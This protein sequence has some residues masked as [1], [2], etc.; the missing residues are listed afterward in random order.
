MNFTVLVNLGCV[1]FI[2]L[3]W[4]TTISVFFTIWFEIF[5]ELTLPFQCSSVVD[6]SGRCMLEASWF[7]SIVVPDELLSSILILKGSRVGRYR[8]APIA[9]SL[10][11]DCP[12][13]VHILKHLWNVI[14]FVSTL[15]KQID[16]KTERK[17]KKAKKI[18]F[19]DSR[20]SQYFDHILPTAHWIFSKQ[21]LL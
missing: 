8:N 18:L 21:V 10:F 17:K 2:S 4:F 12:S 13:L 20:F 9:E 7:R 14:F 6:V 1:W 16:F 15:R 5:F 11:Q 19:F 3:S